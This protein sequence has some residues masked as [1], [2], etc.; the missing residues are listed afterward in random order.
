[1]F[2]LF[3]QG[4]VSGFIAGSAFVLVSLVALNLIGAIK[5]ATRTRRER[6]TETTRFRRT[7]WLALAEHNESER[8]DRIFGVKK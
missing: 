2:T 1:M 4:F 5:H 6:L 3:Q 7:G 8:I